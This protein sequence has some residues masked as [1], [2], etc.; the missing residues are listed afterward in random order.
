MRPS[1][2]LAFLDR[3]APDSC[4]LASHVR[5]ATMTAYFEAVA[6]ASS[7]RRLRAVRDIQ[8]LSQL[9]GTTTLPA[10]AGY[11]GDTEAAPD[12]TPSDHDGF[13]HAE[14]ESGACLRVAKLPAE[15]YALA[16][17]EVA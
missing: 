15:W 4:D 6:G 7:E 12:C 3:N 2:Q 17:T 14:R 8:R 11:E 5:R 9:R 13:A 1:V 10:P 16:D